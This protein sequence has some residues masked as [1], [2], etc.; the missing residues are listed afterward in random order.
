[1]AAA[2]L[3]FDVSAS[4]DQPMEGTERHKR[5]C[6][7]AQRSCGVWLAIGESCLAKRP[8]SLMETAKS[9]LGRCPQ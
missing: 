4:L 8:L 2:F 5:A 6:A 7:V 1:M 3:R 9:V